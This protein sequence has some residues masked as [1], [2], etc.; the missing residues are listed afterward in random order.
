MGFILAS[1]STRLE[2]LLSVMDPKLAVQEAGLS[3][4]SAY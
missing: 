2:A 4:Q 1:G 3:V